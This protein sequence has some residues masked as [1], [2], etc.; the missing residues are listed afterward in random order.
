ME[1]LIPLIF[2]VMSIG[3][4]ML[5]LWLDYRRKQFLH[6]ERMESLRQGITPPDWLAEAEKKAKKTPAEKAKGF[7]IAGGILL[8]IGIWMVVSM[9][10]MGMGYVAF[11]TGAPGFVGLALIAAGFI[12]RSGSKGQDSFDE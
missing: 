5:A 3:I 10:W 4:G 11:W 8:A 2:I 12:I 7:F 6:Q 9:F 1:E